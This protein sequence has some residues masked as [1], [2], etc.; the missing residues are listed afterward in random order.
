MVSSGPT[1][2]TFIGGQV[3]KASQWREVSEYMW[4]RSEEIQQ[5]SKQHADVEGRDKG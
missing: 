2:Y 3:G 5:H 4:V 1:M